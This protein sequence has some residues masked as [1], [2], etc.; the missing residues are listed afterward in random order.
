MDPLDLLL[1][2]EAMPAGQAAG[3]EDDPLEDVV[4]RVGEDMED[5]AEL[6]AVAGVHRG[7]GLERQV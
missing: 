5:A 6:A 4:A 3:V 2:D 7:A 1:V